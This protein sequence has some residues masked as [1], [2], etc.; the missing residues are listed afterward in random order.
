MNGLL[1]LAGIVGCVGAFI[2]AKWSDVFWILGF[3]IVMVLM[4]IIGVQKLVRS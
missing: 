2:P 4:A 3:L 1:A